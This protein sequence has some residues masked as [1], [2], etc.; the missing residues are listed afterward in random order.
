MRFSWSQECFFIKV[1]VLCFVQHT[2]MNEHYW[3][4]LNQ[5]HWDF[6]NRRLD[7]LSEFHDNRFCRNMRL[8]LLSFEPMQVGGRHKGFGCCF[9]RHR[10][11]WNLHIGMFFYVLHH[12]Y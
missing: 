3:W 6:F 5:V 11:P 1:T 10:I 8:S 7:R 12:G 2:L 4:P 9:D